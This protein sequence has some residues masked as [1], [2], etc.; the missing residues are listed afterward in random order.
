MYILSSNCSYQKKIID[1]Y[2]DHMSLSRQKGYVFL[3]KDQESAELA[4]RAAMEHIVHRDVPQ[5][6]TPA[7]R[8]RG[9]YKRCFE[10]D[11]CSDDGVN[12]LLDFTT[13]SWKGKV[14][15]RTSYCRKITRLV[16]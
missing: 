2:V 14:S 4:S 15:T 9:K 16:T 12:V 11:D 7:S 13:S 5:C 3:Y 1:L 8:G 6:I 10:D